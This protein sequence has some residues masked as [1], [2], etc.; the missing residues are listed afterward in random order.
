MLLNFGYVICSIFL[1]KRP[2][3]LYVPCAPPILLFGGDTYYKPAFLTIRRPA[4]VSPP[5]LTHSCFKRGF[6]GPRHFLE[7]ID[8]NDLHPFS[9]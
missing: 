6:Q 5:S 9:R 7:R 1:N 4:A 8:E 3:F 2:L